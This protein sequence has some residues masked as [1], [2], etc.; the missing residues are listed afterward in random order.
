M[1]KPRN[2]G[3]LGYKHF[4]SQTITQLAP[5]YILMTHLFEMFITDSLLHKAVARG[6]GN[7]WWVGGSGTSPLGPKIIEKKNTGLRKRFLSCEKL[8]SFSVQFNRKIVFCQKFLW[9]LV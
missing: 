5:A 3:S 7:W 4:K 2:F 1:A 6:G 9:N 8:F